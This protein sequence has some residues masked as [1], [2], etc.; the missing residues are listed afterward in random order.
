MR[1]RP[2]LPTQASPNATAAVS[3]PMPSAAPT[4][5]TGAPAPAAAPTSRA[6]AQARVN[7]NATSRVL[8]RGYRTL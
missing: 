7:P 3:K 2:S 4:P 5:P 8:K 1:N 6:P